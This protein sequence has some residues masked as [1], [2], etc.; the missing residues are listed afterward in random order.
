MTNKTTERPQRPVLNG[1]CY[2]ANPVTE[3]CDNKDCARRSFDK[4]RG[5]IILFAKN[6]K[7]KTRWICTGCA[8]VE[9]I[10]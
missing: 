7:T 3:K 2:Y 6:T 4:H 8:R 5:Y 1:F 10:I 9:N